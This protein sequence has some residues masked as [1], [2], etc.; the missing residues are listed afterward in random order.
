MGMGARSVDCAVPLL[1][2]AFVQLPSRRRHDAVRDA[3]PVDR[4]F[5]QHSNRISPWHGRDQPVHGASDDFSYTPIA[6]M[7]YSTL[8]AVQ[9]NYR[10]FLFMILALGTSAVLGT[11]LSLD[12][13]L[14]Y[15]FW[16]ATLIPMYFIIGIWG[17]GERIKSTMKFVISVT[18]KRADAGR[19]SGALQREPCHTFDIVAYKDPNVVGLAKS[20]QMWLFW[21]FFLAFAIKVPLFPLHTWLPDAHTDAPTPFQPEA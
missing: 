5:R 20:A 19:D 2:F 18:R 14:F 4:Y 6:I 16:E 9:K 17:S 1:A 11:F 8:N 12:L 21:A 10:E 7:G 3:P 15:V 13:I